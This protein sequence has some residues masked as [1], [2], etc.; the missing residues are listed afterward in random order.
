MG[1]LNEVES[2]HWL[3]CIKTSVPLLPSFK[4]DLAESFVVNGQYGYRDYLEIVK[5]KIGK[6]SDDGEYW[7]DEH[8]GW[9]ICPT[10]FDIEEGYEEGFK[11][12]S[13]A[14]ME[15]DAG[16][17]IVSALAENGIKYE[18]PD[19]RM[20]NNIANAL[21]IAMG[22][23]IETQKE[24]IINCVIDSIRN[25]VETESDYKVW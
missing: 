18:T 7:C 15:D 19:S 8:S 17:K 16:N 10:S 25:T 14:V 13:R 11:V 9:P 3:Y 12:S 24:F 23:N 21:S 4:Y 1:P 6:Q 5:S 22:I 20:I 2:D